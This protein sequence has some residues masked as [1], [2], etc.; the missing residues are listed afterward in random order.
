MR[1]PRWLDGAEA[2]RHLRPYAITGGRTRHSQHTFTLITLVVSRSEA[3]FEYE[4]LEPESV[5]ILELCRDRAVAVAEI[6]A[7]LDLPVSVVK[8][9]CGDLLNAS[10]IIVQSPPGQDEQPSVEIIERVM[11]GIRQL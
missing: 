5:Q 6:A 11:D 7:H 10:L 4:Y 9:L 2:G 8:I 3:E 1:E